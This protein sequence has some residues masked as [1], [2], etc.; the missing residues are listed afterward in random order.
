[1]TLTPESTS[2]WSERLKDVAARIARDFPGEG[3]E[4]QPVHTVYGGAQLYS[5]KTTNRLGEIALEFAQRW[6]PG[7]SE[8]SST[9]GVDS[10]L[11]ERVHAAVF[12]KLRREP[13]EDFRIDFEDGYGNRPDDEEDGHARSTAREVAAAVEEGIVSPF[14]GIRVKSLSGEL[15][16]RALRTL[17]LFVT[18]LVETAEGLPEGFVVTVP[19]LQ[20]VAQV[21]VVTEALGELEDGL[22]I[23]GPIPIELMVETPQ[24]IVDVDGN[25]GVRKW[26]EAAGGRVRGAHFGTYDYTAPS[27]TSGS[28]DPSPAP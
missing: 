5:A 19:K 17:D 23:E 15:H 12:E 18:T 2:S 8:L 1:M 13:V 4:R 24:T 7:P 3:P 16:R 21:E 9:L 28:G 10:D 27:P 14:I 11:A 6:A 26:V 25:V 20:D 22:G